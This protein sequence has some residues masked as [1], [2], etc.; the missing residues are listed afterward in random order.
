MLLDHLKHG[1]TIEDF[2]EGAPTVTRKPSGTLPGNSREH[3]IEC[4]SSWIESAQ[5]FLD[6]Y[7]PLADTMD[8]WN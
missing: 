5:R 1:D 8:K 6:S 3:L 4:A 2:L 7:P